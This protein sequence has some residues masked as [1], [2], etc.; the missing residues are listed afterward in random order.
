[1]LSIPCTPNGTAHWT[2]R[3]ALDGVFPRDRSFTYGALIWLT[4]VLPGTLHGLVAAQAAAG[5]ASAL[6]VFWIA[7]ALLHRPDFLF[8]GMDAGANLHGQV[9]DVGGLGDSGHDADAAPEIIGNAGG[10]GI[11]AEGVFLHHP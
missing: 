8:P 5:A 7:R 3:T 10:F 2:Q 1:M 11:G 4:A 9:S 6:L